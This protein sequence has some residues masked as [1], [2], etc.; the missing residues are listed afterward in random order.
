MLGP[1]RDGVSYGPWVCD[2]V[3]PVAIIPCVLEATDYKLGMAI[4]TLIK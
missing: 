3:H 1:S 4:E 2:S